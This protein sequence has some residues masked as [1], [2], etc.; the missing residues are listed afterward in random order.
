MSLVKPLCVASI[1][2]RTL[3]MTSL[4]ST[5]NLLQQM[6]ILPTTDLQQLLL[7]NWCL[8]VGGA[9]LLPLTQ[10]QEEVVTAA[11]H[12]PQQ[13]QHHLAR[14]CP[15]HVSVLQLSR[16]RRATRDSLVEEH[17][18]QVVLLFPTALHELWNVQKSESGHP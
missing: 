7:A 13:Q 8:Q 15:S 1:A 5:I 12:R 3:I 6:G 10:M 17:H 16:L 18:Q 14:L 2:S 4:S 9:V 11:D